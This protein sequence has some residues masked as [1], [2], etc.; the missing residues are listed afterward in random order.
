MS[1]VFART[2]PREE[3]FLAKAQRKSKDAKRDCHSMKLPFIVNRR[4]RVFRRAA[5]A[6]LL[7]PLISY[8]QSSLV[9][10]VQFQSKL[11]NVTLPYNVILPPDYRTSSRTLYPFLYL[12]H[13]LTGH[14]SYWVTNLIL[15]D[16]VEPSCMIVIML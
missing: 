6:I 7:A 3:S 14:Y 5:L 4:R 1:F 13:C 15:A 2:M 11:V 9:E 10:T 12:L 8:A 16:Y